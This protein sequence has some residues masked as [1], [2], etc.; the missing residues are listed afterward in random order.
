VAEVFVDTNLLLYAISTEQSEERKT[1]IARSV[2]QTM[3][4]AW[5]SQIAGEFVRAST[6]AK[7]PHPISLAQAKTFIQTW[8]AFTMISVD[9][10]IV[11]DAIDVAHRFQISYFDAQVI[12]AAKRLNCKRVYTEDLSHGQDYGGVSAFNPFL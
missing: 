9:E 7:K 5:S 1:L 6:S 12:A 4:W 10:A 2:L 3:N 11:I 8:T